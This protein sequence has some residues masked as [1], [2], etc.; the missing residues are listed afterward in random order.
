[1]SVVCKFLCTGDLHV[2]KFRQF[3]Y[4][5]KDGMNSRLWQCLRVFKIL[6]REAVKREI[7]KILLNGDIFDDADE[8]DTEVY[9]E[10]YRHLERIHSLGIRTAINLGNHDIS[11]Q[12]G[13]RLVHSLQAFRKV[14]QVITKP[15]R[16]WNAVA[17]VPWQPTVSTTV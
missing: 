14:A 17:V 4:T 13:E 6:E 5:R 7:N 3:A 16:I 9:G 10:V 11:L 12:S 15:A 1:M 2:N 8:I